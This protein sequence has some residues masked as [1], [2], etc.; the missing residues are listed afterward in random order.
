MSELQPLRHDED[1]MAL[2]NQ[3][4]KT[5]P[6]HTKEVHNGKFAFTAIDP[7][8]QLEEATRRFGPYGV[9]WGLYDLVFNPIPVDGGTNLLLTATFRY[10]LD[11]EPHQFPIAVDL[12]MRPT[13][14]TAKKLMT[15]ARSKAL[16]YLGFNADVF[17]GKFEDDA[18][19]RDR[20]TEFGD[21]ETTESEIRGKIRT[22]MDT[23]TLK[24]FR[25]RIEQMAATGTITPEVGSRLVGEVES[26]TEE[27]EKSQLSQETK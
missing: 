25:S 7:T 8:Y 23:S 22:A 15:M 5:N 16:S 2:W 17:A 9:A 12:R 26:R 4:C 27:I 14:D 6:G 24:K 19:V 20:E 21:A 18:Y 13:D 10:P 11:G 1:P 3:V